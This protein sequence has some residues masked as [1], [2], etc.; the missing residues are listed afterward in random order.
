MLYVSVLPCLCIV[1]TYFVSGP[2]ELI[3]DQNQTVTVSVG[4][5]VILNCS[6]SS[7]P[8]SEYIWSIPDSCSSCP[9]TTND[10]FLIFTAKN[11][12]DSGE[13][14]CLAE[15]E[16]GNLSLTTFDVIIIS[17][18]STIHYMYILMFCIQNSS[19]AENKYGNIS[20][21]FSILVNGM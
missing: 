21:V 9:S 7:S 15:N 6:V 10:N 14:V 20:V 11:I 8:D 17:K 3:S 19:I 13:Y 4:K 5:E 2:Q 16:S 12:S 18:Y 1:L